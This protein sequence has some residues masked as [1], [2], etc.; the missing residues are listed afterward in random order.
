LNKS[1]ALVVLHEIYDLVRES[2]SFTSVSLDAKPIE[3]LKVGYQIS[4]KGELDITSR[5]L[6]ETILS[7]HQLVMSEE[8]GSVF[9]C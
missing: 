9:I 4:M 5:Q 2:A 7:K 3:H 6:I 8:K 1:E